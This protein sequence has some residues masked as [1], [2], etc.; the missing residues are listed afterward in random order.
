MKKCDISANPTMAS[1]QK[2]SF[3]SNKKLSKGKSKREQ[4][5][6][7]REEQNLERNERVVHFATKTTV[8]ENF[9]L[10]RAEKIDKRET[11]K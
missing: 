4:K 2:T 9:P 6:A 10:Y 7:I 3:R 11:S 8:G 5:A 1:K